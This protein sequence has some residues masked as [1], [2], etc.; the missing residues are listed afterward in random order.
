MVS[1]SLMSKYTLYYS[2]VE[3]KHVIICLARNEHHSR[4]YV[5]ERNR[6]PCIFVVRRHHDRNCLRL[7]RVSYKN[8][9][10]TRHLLCQLLSRHTLYSCAQS[11]RFAA[12]KY[13]YVFLYVFLY[14]KLKLCSYFNV[15]KCPFLLNTKITLIPN[16][17]LSDLVY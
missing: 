6:L 13:V 15:F 14:F 12:K 9:L 17:N 7:D 2:L 5:Q 11:K 16:M 3:N 10:S 4:D 8:Q 1:I